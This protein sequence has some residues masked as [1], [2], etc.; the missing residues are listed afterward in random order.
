MREFDIGDLLVVRKHVNS[1]RKYGIDQK[2]VF[3]TKGQYRFLE[4]A[5]P[6][7]YWLHHLHFY[8]GI[9]RHGRKVN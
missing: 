2:L 1:S 4:K 8:E 3:K 5:T 7:S 9:G 6:R